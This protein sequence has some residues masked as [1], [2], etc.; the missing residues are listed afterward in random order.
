MVEN[1]GI[2]GLIVVALPF[3][4]EWLKKSAWFPWLTAKSDGVV[5]FWSAF[6]AAASSWGVTIQS[7]W[8]VGHHAIEGLTAWVLLELAL[9]FVLQF[10]G[11]E[12]IYRW[13]VKPMARQ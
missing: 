9:R 7:D 3:I 8:T 4:L 13:L 11:Q 2:Q 5:R 1:I 12:G 10:V 6:V